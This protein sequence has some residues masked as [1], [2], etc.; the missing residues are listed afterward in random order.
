MT[1]EWTQG[2]ATFGGNR[3]VINSNWAG[4]GHQRNAPVDQLPVLATR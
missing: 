2:R 4:F 3:R 1:L